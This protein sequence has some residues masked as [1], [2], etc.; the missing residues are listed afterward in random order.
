ML[1]YKIVDKMLWRTAEATG[2]FCGSADDTRDGFIH[3]STGTQAP[4]TARKYF[5]GRDD[6]LLVAV[7]PSAFGAAMRW[8]VSRGG[9]KFPHLYQSLTL[10]KVV[11][12]KTLPMGED[13]LHRFPQEI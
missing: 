1:V 4:V 8:E 9:E 10:S 5:G 13:G 2:I 7:D 12:V 6:L 11:W 3:F